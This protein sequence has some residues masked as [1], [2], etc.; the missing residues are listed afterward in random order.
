MRTL[1]FTLCDL[2]SLR[3][4]FSRAVSVLFAFSA[5]ASVFRD[6]LQAVSTGLATNSVQRHWQHVSLIDILKLNAYL[7]DPC[8]LLGTGTMGIPHLIATL[9]PYAVHSLLEDDNIVVDGPALAYHIFHVCRN[10]GITQPSYA[11]LGKATI[12]WLDRLA[13]NRVVV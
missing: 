4:G 11:V 12:D 3:W 10:N 9:E 8:H 2:R 1:Y 13:D 7:V 5:K 6:E